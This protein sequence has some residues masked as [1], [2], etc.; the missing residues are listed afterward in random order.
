M[1]LLEMNIMEYIKPELLCLVAVVVVLGRCF[2]ESRIQ[3]KY[4]PRI[5]MISSIVLATLWV[6]ATS[7]LETSSEIALAIFTGFEMCIR[8][9]QVPQ[10][11]IFHLKEQI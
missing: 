7:A 3:D 10:E 1:V 8:D 11:Q 9:R 6:I 2:K 5:L 4:I